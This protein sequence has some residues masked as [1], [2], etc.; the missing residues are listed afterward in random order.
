MNIPLPFP[1][2]THCKEQSAYS[3][4][5]RDDCN[6][7]LEIDPDT[8]TVVCSACGREWDI[9]ESRYYCSCGNVFDAVDVK[10][11]VDELTE[12]SVKKLQND[13]GF[14]I[15]GIVGPLLW[16]KVVELSKR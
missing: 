16:R 13:Y 8:E 14:E 9:W 5:H 11:A 4:H 15:N 7:L 12:K 1:Y 3:Y 10:E 6:G 2:C